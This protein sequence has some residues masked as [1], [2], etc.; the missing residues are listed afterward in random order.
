MMYL[1][2]ANNIKTDEEAVLGIFNT[3]EEAWWNINFNLEWDEND[4]K[5]NWWFTVQEIDENYY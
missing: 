1:A 4:V 3:A 5:E 2:I